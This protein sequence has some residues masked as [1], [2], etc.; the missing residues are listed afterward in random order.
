MPRPCA[1]VF[2]FTARKE[3]A[4]QTLMPRPC[5]WFL[6]LPLEKGA[7]QTLMPRP[8]AVVL[9]FTARKEG[10]IQTLMPR[11]CAVV[12]YVQC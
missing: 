6:R 5:A 3:G 12:F 8:C 1:V 11:P 2:T 7:I 9:T 10:A 4:I